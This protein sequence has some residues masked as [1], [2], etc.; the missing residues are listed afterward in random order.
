[1]SR[2]SFYQ[3][4]LA[5]HFGKYLPIL[6]WSSSFL[7]KLKVLFPAFLHSADA[8]ILLNQFRIV[9]NTFFIPSDPSW[10]QTNHYL[11]NFIFILFLQYHAQNWP[12]NIRSSWRSIQNTRWNAPVVGICWQ[13]CP[14]HGKV[15]I[16][17]NLKTKDCQKTFLYPRTVL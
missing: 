11:N 6:L 10:V 1:M 8:Y 9:S 5:C 3:H 17:G 14:N 7:T 12:T 2:E 13:P 15:Y 16:F 4:L